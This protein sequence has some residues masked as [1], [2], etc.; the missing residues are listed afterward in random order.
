M[1]NQNKCLWGA[2]ALLLS[3]VHRAD[4]ASQPRDR[5]QTIPV[6]SNEV[7]S[8]R[9]QVLRVASAAD[10][11]GMILEIKNLTGKPLSIQQTW[12]GLDAERRDLI[13][14]KAICSGSLGPG[15]VFG[16]VITSGVVRVSS[17]IW[18]W[19]SDGLGCPP[20]SGLKVVACLRLDL[21]AGSGHFASPSRGFAFNWIY[22]DAK[23]IGAM[24][25]RLKELLRNPQYK[26]EHGEQLRTLFAYPEVA[27]DLTAGELL[28]ALKLRQNT[29]DGRNVIAGQLGRRFAN[30]PNVVVFASDE[31]RKGKIDDVLAGG[32]WNPVFVPILVDNFEKTGDS[33]TLAYV[34][35]SHRGDWASDTQVVTRLSAALLK[36][37]PLLARNVSRLGT[38]DLFAWAA[39]A[40]EAAII[41]DRGLLRILAPALDDERMAIHPHENEM[42]NMPDRRR[43]SD[44]ALE[45]IASIMGISV[46]QEYGL[47]RGRLGFEPLT[48]CNRAI[49]DVKKRMSEL[50]SKPEAK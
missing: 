50:D 8:A 15:S 9:L 45:A 46:Y 48:N 27:E 6:I 40:H 36:H 18:P 17:N 13:T 43:M 41:G 12:F 5:W 16:G 28:D 10:R 33:S 2:F 11:H 32:I 37:R 30:D 22:P 7:L 39:S 44:H 20:K 25:D 31:L 35:G 19:V 26:F 29:V 23:E 38:N 49:A 24:K 14:D 21:M 42:A 34:L 1:R 3:M 4:A 47:H